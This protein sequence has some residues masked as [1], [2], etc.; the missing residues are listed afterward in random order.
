LWLLGLFKVMEFCHCLS[1]TRNSIYSIHSSYYSIDLAIV[2]IVF[3][4]GLLRNRVFDEGCSSSIGNSS[5]VESLIS[6]KELVVLKESLLKICP[7]FSLRPY[8]NDWSFFI[9]FLLSFLSKSLIPLFNCL[10]LVYFS[11][12]ILFIV[13]E[14]IFFN[15]I[16]YLSIM[17]YCFI[18][19]ILVF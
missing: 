4:N 6:V 5:K 7:T 3:T 2:T 13:L 1:L 10:S 15:F 14:C 12:N 11:L 16:I 17:V 9:F 8:Y 19:S 18:Q